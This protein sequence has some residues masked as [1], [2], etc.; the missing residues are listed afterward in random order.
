MCF[1]SSSLP[2][3]L[4]SEAPSRLRVFC[5]SCY[6]RP[7]LVLLRIQSLLRAATRLIFSTRRY[8]HNTSCSQLLRE[9]TRLLEHKPKFSYALPP[10]ASVI[11]P[12]LSPQLHSRPPFSVC[13]T[14]T[15]THTRP[16]PRSLL[17]AHVPCCFAHR[18]VAQTGSSSVT[19]ASLC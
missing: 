10:R 11:W 13:P 3:A 8:L 9:F 5:L 12:R 1:R 16:S 6:S 4:L 15:H 19:S 14:P 18:A 2:L 7:P 17:G